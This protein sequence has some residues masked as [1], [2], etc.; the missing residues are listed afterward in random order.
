MKQMD[1]LKFMR[2][3]ESSRNLEPLE[4]KGFFEQESDKRE[5]DSSAYQVMSGFNSATLRF[6]QPPPKM[7]EQAP[8]L[9][10]MRP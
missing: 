7:R 6:V 8:R 3:K 1:R 10:R 2:E 9:Q 5:A 4:N